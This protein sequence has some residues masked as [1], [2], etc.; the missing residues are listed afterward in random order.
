MCRRFVSFQLRRAAAGVV[1]AEVGS[2]SMGEDKLFTVARLGT[3]VWQGKLQARA[4]ECRR[5][6]LSTKTHPPAAPL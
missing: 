6:P 2:R 4:G 3:Q 1:M 5:K